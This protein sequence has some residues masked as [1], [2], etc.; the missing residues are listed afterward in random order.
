MLV[1]TRQ[2]GLLSSNRLVSFVHVFQPFAHLFVRCLGARKIFQR[3]EIFLLLFHRTDPHFLFVT[4]RGMKRTTWELADH[5]ACNKHPRA[6]RC[7]QNP[8]HI[9][10]RAGYHGCRTKFKKTRDMF[11]VLYHLL[12]LFPLD[13]FVLLVEIVCLFFRDTPVCLCLFYRDTIGDCFN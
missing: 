6:S 4:R 12:D 1:S 2:L 9:V 8:H 5:L 11:H 13:N 7:L 3:K 10:A